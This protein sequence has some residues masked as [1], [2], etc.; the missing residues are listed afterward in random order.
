MRPLAIFL[1]G[2]VI[3]FGLLAAVI[4]LS[5]PTERLFV[6]VDGSF[7]MRSVWNQVPGTLAELEDQDY[8]EYALATEKRLVHSWQPS[9]VLRAPAPY[10]PCDLGGLD[11][12]TEAAEAD[13]RVLITTPGSC[14]TDGL[15][16]WQVISLSP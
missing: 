10:A 11:A 9:L 13:A 14:P 8:A 7:P 12:Y 2:V 6:V 3:V 5:R 16:D 1:V 4:V 15:A